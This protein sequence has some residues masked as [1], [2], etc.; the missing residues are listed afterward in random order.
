[1]NRMGWK[2]TI[3]GMQVEEAESL[4]FVVGVSFWIGGS[5]TRKE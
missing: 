1:M 5:R 4:A 3:T 2:R